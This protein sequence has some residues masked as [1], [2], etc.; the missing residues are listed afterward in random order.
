VNIPS[1]QLRVIEADQVKRI[2]NVVVGRPYT[3][4]P[5]ITS[6]IEKITTVPRWNVPK[7][8]TFNEILPRVKKDST[9]LSRNN[10]KVIDKQLN[11][12]S[13]NNMGWKD[14]NRDNFD[15]YFVQRSGS[16]NALGLLKFS[17]KNPY[18]IYIHDTPSKR[19][20]NKDIRAYSH[21]CI[22]LQ[23]PDQFASYLVENNLSAEQKP[24]ISNLVARRIHKNINLSEPIDIHVRYL[25]CEAD[26]NLN[27]YFYMDIYNKDE[28]LMEKSF[29]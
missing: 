21:G 6:R 14:M 2:F 3:P 18:R 27:L 15:Y 1:Y 7:S 4:T 16:S 29:N 25:T 24:D 10:F 5:E 20:F 28:A 13:I 19:Y 17:F 11:E 8:I 26:E 22:R 23:N 12:V 9:Y